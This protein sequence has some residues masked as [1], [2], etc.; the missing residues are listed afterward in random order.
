[1]A[2]VD[3]KNALFGQPHVLGATCVGEDTFTPRQMLELDGL[4]KVW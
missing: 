4:K 1:V 2:V 3:A